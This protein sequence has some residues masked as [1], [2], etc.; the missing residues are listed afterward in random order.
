MKNFL[1]AILAFLSFSVSAEAPK[2]FGQWTIGKDGQFSTTL[3]TNR[4]N[5]FAIYVENQV[6]FVIDKTEP[7]IDNKYGPEQKFNTGIFL[8]DA[9][10]GR[11]VIN[12]T[13]KV[14][15]I[16][17]R[18]KRRV[19][20]VDFAEDGNGLLKDAF[21]KRSAVT[22]MLDFSNF[23]YSAQGYTAASLY[24]DEQVEKAKQAEAASKSEPVPQQVAKPTPPA[25]REYKSV[26]KKASSDSEAGGA[27]M[28]ILAVLGLVVWVMKAEG[29]T[30]V[31]PDEPVGKDGK[32]KHSKQ[33][34]KWKYQYRDSDM[35]RSIKGLS[36]SELQG[37]VCHLLASKKELS[38]Q[39]EIEQNKVKSI[40][41]LERVGWPT[42]QHFAEGMQAFEHFK[43]NQQYH[44]LIDLGRYPLIGLL[45]QTTYQL[46][47]VSEQLEQALASSG[48]GKPS[49]YELLGCDES[50]PKSELKKRYRRAVAACHPDKIGEAGKAL[51][52]M[53]N[54][55]WSKI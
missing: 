51:T 3:S 39:L 16:D 19:Y 7:C 50:I 40:E 46:V 18:T 14:E 32:H 10:N 4:G 54:D 38:D 41:N 33:C 48:S 47:D 37:F 1:I 26:T 28:G 8:L 29:K 17:S 42:H 34:N 21:L 15:C 52:A 43:G 20:V 31:V 36:E 45:I 11:R 35:M 24:V 13:K 9:K 6:A 2:Q 23:S 25:K 27:V 12:T 49:I 44:D 55:A 22:V 5:S 30:K 53:L